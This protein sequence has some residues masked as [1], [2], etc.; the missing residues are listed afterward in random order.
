MILELTPDQ[1]HNLRG[2]LY[3]ALHQADEQARF[4]SIQLPTRILNPAAKQRRK[5]ERAVICNHFQQLQT[6]SDLLTNSTAVILYQP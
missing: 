3:L 1:L 5:K 6:L 2:S 4:L